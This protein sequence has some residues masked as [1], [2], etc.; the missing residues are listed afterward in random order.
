MPITCLRAFMFKLGILMLIL[1]LKKQGMGLITRIVREETRDA[2]T[3][4]YIALGELLMLMKGLNAE[5]ALV[6]TESKHVELVR[7]IPEE[8]KRKLKLK[9]LMLEKRY[10]VKEIM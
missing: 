10:V 9:I 3:N 1:R 8:L 4:F 2:K 5:Y 7:K 6:L